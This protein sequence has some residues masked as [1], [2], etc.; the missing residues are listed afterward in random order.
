MREC[1]GRSIAGGD[2]CLVGNMF[3]FGIQTL[4]SA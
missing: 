4:R 1:I 3:E 2:R